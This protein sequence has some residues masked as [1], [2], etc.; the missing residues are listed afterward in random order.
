MFVI[1]E[2]VNIK[3]SNLKVTDNCKMKYYLFGKFKP[4]TC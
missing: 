1:R 2:T 3:V 4:Y